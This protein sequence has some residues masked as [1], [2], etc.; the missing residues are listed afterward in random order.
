MFVNCFITIKERK[1][2]QIKTSLRLI[3]VSLSNAMACI[4][5]LY[6]NL[7]YHKSFMTVKINI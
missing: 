2:K 1:G 3:S 4:Y 6:F 5:V 7:L